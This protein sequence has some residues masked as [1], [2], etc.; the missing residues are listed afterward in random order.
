MLLRGLL[1]VLAVL[2]ACGAHASEADYPSNSRAASPV[3]SGTRARLH[4]LPC[5][6]GTSFKKCSNI[7]LTGE[8]TIADGD[9][10]ALR[11]KEIARAV[12]TL[13]GEGGSTFAA[14]KIGE[15][16]H[17]KKYATV[18]NGFCFSACAYIW[19]AGQD[20][21]LG[22]GG[23]VVFH[24]SYNI[25]QE[26]VADGSG[27]ALLGMYMARLGYNYDDVIRTIGHGPNDL[28]VVFMKLDG[29]VDRRNITAV[30]FRAILAGE[31]H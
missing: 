30:E 11:T 20:R 18:V 5:E 3:P 8:L 13:A 26:D 17:A 29:V 9:A 1:F 4:I 28:H 19:I 6:A 12:V 23:M 24:P 21:G 16:I 10:F 27:N 2:F 7:S 31:P 22:L 25:E 15:I 14:I